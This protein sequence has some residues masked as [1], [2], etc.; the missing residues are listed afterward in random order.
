MKMKK[1][2][3]E[4]GESCIFTTGNIPYIFA[5]NNVKMICKVLNIKYV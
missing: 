3:R 4:H 2:F 1:L 5:G